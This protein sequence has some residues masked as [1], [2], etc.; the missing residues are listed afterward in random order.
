[1]AATNATERKGT[2]DGAAHGAVQVQEDN[3]LKDTNH[4]S[5]NSMGRRTAV[6]YL[7]ME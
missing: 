6:A 2:K 3:R 7:E 4:A 1:M 5:I